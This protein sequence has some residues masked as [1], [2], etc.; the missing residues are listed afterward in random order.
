MCLLAMDSFETFFWTCSFVE[1]TVIMA[2]YAVVIVSLVASC[3]CKKESA[4]EK[5]SN[6]N[7]RRC[8]GGRANE[9][10]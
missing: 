5:D 3:F 1:M 6:Q 7:G 2:F 8:S 10:D 9:A 4:D